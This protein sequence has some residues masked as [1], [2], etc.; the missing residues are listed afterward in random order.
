MMR[1]EGAVD[2]LVQQDVLAGQTRGQLLNDVAGRAVSGV[3]RN[4]QRPVA[5]IVARQPRDV[6]LADHTLFDPSSLAA[7]SFEARG[8][9][10]EF[11]DRRPAK[12]LALEDELETIVIARAPGRGNH[13]PAIDP[14]RRRRCIP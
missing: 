10:A 12:R 6:F 5:V 7:W 8:R 4:G 13:D 9:L 3:P 14:E 11:L 1:R 2:R